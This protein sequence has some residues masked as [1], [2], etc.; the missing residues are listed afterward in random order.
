MDNIKTRQTYLQLWIVT[1]YCIKLLE[2]RI[3]KS[4]SKKEK[5]MKIIACPICNDKE[6]YEI[7]RGLI[8]TGK[9]YDEGDYY[10]CK[11]CGYEFNENGEEVLK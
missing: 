9:G 11:G 8:W 4:V 2:T 3:S 5:K 6:N 1:P 7:K 10:K